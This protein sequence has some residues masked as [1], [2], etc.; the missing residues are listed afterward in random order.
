[1]N[2]EEYL[3][4]VDVLLD[5][6][7]KGSQD[8]ERTADAY[9]DAGEA[10]LEEVRGGG[11]IRRLQTLRQA[12]EKQRKP[13]EAC[14]KTQI[15]NLRGLDKL[16][17]QWKS[18]GRNYARFVEQASRLGHTYNYDIEAM[19]EATESINRAVEAFDSFIKA[20]R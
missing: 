3:R 13:A 18:P 6:L 2:D 17:R 16:L 14:W 10:F 20:A 4:N 8:L 5:R 15:N 12:V 1:M 9:M 7:W 19:V 11:N